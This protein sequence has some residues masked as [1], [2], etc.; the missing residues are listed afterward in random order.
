M[1]DMAAADRVA[2]SGFHMPFPSL[3]DVERRKD[4]GYRWLGHASQL[5]D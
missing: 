1:F 5:Q 4:G 3:G 2:V